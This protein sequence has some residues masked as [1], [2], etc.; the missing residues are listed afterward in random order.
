VEKGFL[1][2]NA[3]R[4]DRH[5]WVIAN[6]LCEVGGEIRLPTG[7]TIRLDGLGYHDHRYGTGPI[8][9]GVR[10]WLC[11]RV[12]QD[13]QAVA[14]QIT[15]PSQPDQVDEAHVFK[16]DHSAAGAIAAPRITW[17]SDRF[18]AWG[19]SYPTAVD[20]GRTLILRQPRLLDC[21]PFCMRLMYDAFVDGES[22]SALCQ[23]VYPH[24]L[25]WPILGRWIEKSITTDHSRE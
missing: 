24:R 1:R 7:R 16:A 18:T 13:N 10:R 5:Y 11:G 4:V 19:L 2:G 6:P 3:G 14:F 8:G 17:G 20:I 15:T 25:T 12:L 23:I 21:S 22:A 9:P